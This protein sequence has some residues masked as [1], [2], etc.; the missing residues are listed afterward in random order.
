MSGAGYATITARRYLRAAEH[1]IYWSDRNRRPVQDADEKFLGQFVHHLDRCRCPHQGHADRASLTQGTRLFLEYLR[2]SGINTTL[3][4]TP[5]VA[6]DST[7]LSRYCEWMRLQRGTCDATLSHHRRYVRELLV[8]LGEVPSQWDAH[9][10]R[11]DRDNE[12]AAAQRC[13]RAASKRR[14][15]TTRPWISFGHH[16]GG[17]FVPSAISG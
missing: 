14:Q 3:S 2:E 10:L 9:G 7:L 15:H 13:G 17:S 11:S 6:A 1:F 5:S 4:V 8:Q 12:Q 16:R